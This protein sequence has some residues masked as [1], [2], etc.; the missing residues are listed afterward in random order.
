[1]RAHPGTGECPLVIHVIPSPL[2]RGAQRAAR[3]LVDRLDQPGTVHHRLLGLFD[4]PPEVA[5]DLS[6]GIPGGSQAAEGFRPGV[7]LRLRRLLTRLNVAAVV[8]HGGDSMKYAL[9]AMI[10]TG[11]PLIYCVIGTYA[12]ASTSLHEWGWRQGMAR[13]DLVVAV[14]NEVLDECTRR[15][16]VARERAV[17]IPNGR[18]PLQFHPGSSRRDAPAAATVIFVGALTPQKD[19][20][21]FI[22]VVGQLRAGGRSFRAKLVGDGPLAGMLAAPAADKGVEVLGSR[23][24]V[25]ELLRQAD[26]L[27]FTS[28]PTGEGMPGVLIEAGLSGLA[29]VAT[30]VPGAAT[31]L[32]DGRTGLI[33]D[34]SLAKM[35]GA[36]A[37]LLDDPVRRTAM[38]SAARSRCE[39]EFTLDL[40]AE[41]WQAALSPMVRPQG[42]AARRGRVGTGRSAS[43]LRRSMRNRRGSSHS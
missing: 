23:A 20:G 28:Q 11:W 30:S 31:V 3:L 6:L 29:A 25:P 38:G 2:G 12:G 37:Q 15:F 14:G 5:V 16:G 32:V 36:V 17:M 18:D 40:M 22:E 24:D 27:V 1:M 7:A 41:R 4:G 39:S 13:A 10:G 19:P 43:A 33:V 9:P 42:R 34:Y 35:V 21:R 26:V 8:A